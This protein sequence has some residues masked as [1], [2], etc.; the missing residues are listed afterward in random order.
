MTVLVNK[1]RDGF[2]LDS[3]ALMRLSSR[4]AEM[5]GVAEAVLM[6]GTP[7]NKRIM[8]EAGL[9]N[10]DGQAASANDLVV[11]LRA[12][13]QRVADQ[14][15]AAALRG[16]EEQAVTSGGPDR[17][18][19]G[20]LPTALRELPQANLAL[21]STPGEYAARE[22]AAALAQG[23]NV[24]IFSDNVPLDAEIALK[25]TAQSRGLIVMGPDC[26]TA[27]IGGQPLAFCNVVPRGEI[28][29]VAASGTGLQEVISLVAR[30]GAGIS[31]GI[32]VGGRDLQDDVGGI[33]T[34]TAL[35]LL[36][37]DPQTRHVVL[38]SKPPG[39]RTAE[40]VYARLAELGKPAT[41]CAFDG[42]ALSVS[43]TV[44][45]ADTLH[46][47]VEACLDRTLSTPPPPGLERPD[48]QGCNA[49]AWFTGG[50]LCNEALAIFRRAGVT[51][52]SNL[53]ARASGNRAGHRFIDLGAD[54]YTVGR[55]HPMIDPTVRNTH[56]AATLRDK[57]VGVLLLDV[58]LGFGA[59]PD[60]AGALLDTITAVPPTQRPMII[61][62]VC[63]TDAD[64]QN[65]SAQVSSLKRHGVFVAG[66][67]AEATQWALR[68][69]SGSPAG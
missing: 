30:H 10:G 8:A 27:L 4:L 52:A 57:T 6:I 32:G 44:T 40:R 64:P 21:I 50:T 7:N 37:D 20:S 65:R 55:P 59:H 56:V 45:V 26:G 13:S 62:S 49:H 1:V 66:S 42:D 51:V 48:A 43:E 67:N 9:L 34:L 46:A 69:V 25:R 16:L 29:V 11:A 5:P 68:L 28:G 58:V 60:P 31:H 22:A 12:D 15:L 38:I 14:A 41:V 53:D 47:T 36:A 17:R 18:S 3:V 2:Y 19:V 33:S 35:E 23:L 54:E 63:G 39:P 24:M 61:A